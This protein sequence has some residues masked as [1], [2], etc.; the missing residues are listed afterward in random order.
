M[1]AYRRRS[2]TWRCWKSYGCTPI[3]S[4]ARFP[5][6][7]GNLANLRWLFLADNKLS[8]QIPEALNNLTLDR[9]WLQKNSFTGCVPYNLTQTREYKVDSGLP[10][11]AQG[12]VHAQCNADTRAPWRHGPRL[13]QHPTPTPAPTLPDARLTAIE[14]RL[15]DIERRVAAFGNASGWADGFHPHPQLQL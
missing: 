15:T 9:L 2:A 4:P 14:G 11:C 10:A 1:V 3:S 13:L 8:G 12:G 5:P 6:A 7:M